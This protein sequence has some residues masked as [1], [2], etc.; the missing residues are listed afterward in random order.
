MAK[1]VGIL[2]A[3]GDTPGLNSAIRSIGK[4]ARGMGMNVIGYDPKITVR[5]AWQLSSGVEHAET[6]DQLFQHS[7]AVTVHVPL[8]DETRGLVNRDRLALMPENGVK[9]E[10][11]ADYLEGKVFFCCEDCKN[12]FDRKKN[13]EAIM[14]RANEQLFAT[15][16]YEQRLCP[17]TG[18]TLD[19]E[20]FGTPGRPNGL[21]EIAVLEGT[22][23]DDDSA[24]IA[25]HP[26]A[27]NVHRLYDQPFLYRSDQT[28]RHKANAVN[29]QLRWVD[30]ARQDD[31]RQEIRETDHPLVDGR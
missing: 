30:V 3:G 10:L 17:F 25:I 12:A 13:D 23:I 22:C 15:G 11:W 4:T 21:C 6:L 26:R 27:E 7:D 28:Q 9:P 31:R 29:T 2:T 18:E 24:R 14:L 20:N 1:Y 19:D 5:R 8:F 16:Q